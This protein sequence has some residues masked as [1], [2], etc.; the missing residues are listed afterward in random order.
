[1]EIRQLKYF[2]GVAEEL[3][4]GNAA[5]KLF[6]SQS[7]LSQQ[8]QLLE[9]ELGTDLFF[10]NKRNHQ[11]KVELTEA[12]Q[13]L[14]SDAKNIILLCQR[15]VSTV[16]RIGSQSNI[17]KLGFPRLVDPL[18]ITKLIQLFRLH[19]PNIVLKIIEL[20]SIHS[21]EDELMSEIIDMGIVLSSDHLPDLN[22]VTLFNSPS[23]ILLSSN[24]PLSFASAITVDQ[25]EG[26][27]WI[28]LK[29]QVNPMY[30]KVEAFFKGVSLK[31]EI[32]QEVNS[33]EWI[34]HL[35]ALGHG[36]GIVPAHLNLISSTKTISLPLLSEYK[37]S[38]PELDI[39]VALA[40]YKKFDQGKI[41]KVLAHYQI[42]E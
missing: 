20:P 11:H 32:V 12:G 30:D 4:F 42:G 15:S 21:V 24:H 33:Y 27:Q 41:A 23:N 19:Y 16:Q 3:H 31:R 5:K 17:L 29:R 14:L 39:C 10:R 36:I 7:A 38:L 26:E 6:V 34:Q 9:N 13:A 28:E 2:I 18:V 25:L 8:I 37:S 40:T 35:V 1:M 22:T